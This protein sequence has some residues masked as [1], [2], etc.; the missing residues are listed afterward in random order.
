MMKKLAFALA[1]CLCANGLTMAVPLQ[2]PSALAQ[3]QDDAAAEEEN[4]AP[5]DTSEI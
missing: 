4:A 5:D 3:A 2:G 1:L